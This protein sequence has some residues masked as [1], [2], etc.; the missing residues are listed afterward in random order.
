[1][2]I[3]QVGLGLA[4]L[5]LFLYVTS[6]NRRQI[7]WRMIGAGLLLQLALAFLLLRVPL[8]GEALGALN[9]LVQ[10]MEKVTTDATSFLFGYL[11]GAKPPFDSERPEAEFIVAFRILPLIMVISAISSLLYHWRILPWIIGHIASFFRK[12]LHIR[13][14]LAFGSAATIFLG[15]IEAP[16][17]VRPYLARMTRSD[18]FA[19]ITCTM[20]TIAGTV[21]VLY[22]SALGKVV[23]NALGHMLVASLISIPAAV[24]IAKTMIPD[25]AE[26][27]A[28]LS[29]QAS[30]T[31]HPPRQ[32]KS[33]MEAL[34]NGTLDGLDMVLKI[35]AIIIVL[36]ALIYLCNHMLAL[37]P[38][39][40]KWTV[41]SLLGTI[42]RPVMWLTGIPWA[43]AET[44][45]RLMGTKII[46]NE[47]V[48][49]LQLSSLAPETFSDQTRLIVTYALCGFANLASAGIVI[50]GLKTIL[51]ERS[52]EVMTLAMKSLISGNL[53]TLM[54]AGLIGILI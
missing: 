22:A 14:P 44:A 23:P 9:A 25:S 34:I 39:D 18:L 41:E 15:T 13:G 20:A 47:F 12:T 52:E 17:L 40:G 7:P 33:A 4:I 29:T 6:E 30:P 27:K 5:F 8:I 3:V 43:E 28:T 19:L 53:A 11:A 51:P 37:I 42:L 35:S 26:D 46:L 1:V 16:L 24:I 36:F 10:V 31:E 49:Y 2:S 50:G 32:T 21:M 45:G 38:G 48:A 54:T